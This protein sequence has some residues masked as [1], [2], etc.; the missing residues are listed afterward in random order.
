M[1]L[2][3]TLEQVMRVAPYCPVKI[4]S[5]IGLLLSVRKGLLWFFRN[6]FER[7]LQEKVEVG[8]QETE[9]G[10]TYQLDHRIDLAVA[11]K[12]QGETGQDDHGTEPFGSPS[13]HSQRDRPRHVVREECDIGQ[14]ESLHEPFEQPRI[15]GQGMLVARRGW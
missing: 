4:G 5:S 7:I 8:A 2:C 13:N 1:A 12:R 9:Q 15:A 6:G 11:L 10:R 14:P 3:D